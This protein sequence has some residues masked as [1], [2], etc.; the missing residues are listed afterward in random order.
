MI[1]CI[2]QSN[3]HDIYVVHTV[4]CVCGS[5][6]ADLPIYFKVTPPVLYQAKDCLDA[7]DAAVKDIGK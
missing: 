2:L 7:G 4:A 6:L 5:A 1:S 3:Y